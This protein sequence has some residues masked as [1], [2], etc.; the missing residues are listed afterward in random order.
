MKE[1]HRAYERSNGHRMEFE[2]FEE[3]DWGPLYREDV[4]P[5]KDTHVNPD[6]LD[7]NLVA[8]LVRWAFQAKRR[9]GQ[10]SLMEI[11]ELYL[12]SGHHSRDLREMI[13]Y[14]CDMV[15]E[16]PEAYEADP[17]QECVDLIHQ[18]H[19]ILAGGVSITYLRVKWSDGDRAYRPD[20][21]F[22]RGA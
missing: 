19:G 3:D 2:E 5:S 1:T 9:M 13:G 4:S 11:V 20:R 10:E 18:L 6:S 15:E 16:D 17:A 22:S 12:R 21:M 7:V 14:I 8:N